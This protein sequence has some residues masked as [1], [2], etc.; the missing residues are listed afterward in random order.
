MTLIFQSYRTHDVP[1][2]I[3]LCLKSVQEWTA[4]QG[5]EYRFI[6]DR[7]FDYAPSWYR[8]KVQDNV[9]LV[10]DL[11]RLILAQEFLQEG[12]E[13]VIWMDADLL[14]FDPENFHI[15]TTKGFS[16]CREVW[17]DRD[18]AGKEVF[19]EKVNNS[20]SVFCRDEHFLDFYVDACL[21]IVREAAAVTPVLVGT[22]FLTTLHG[23]YPFPLLQQVGILSPALVDALLH[24][25]TGFIAAYLENQGTPVVAANLCGSKLEEFSG[26]TEITASILESSIEK[27]LHQK[28]LLP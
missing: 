1:D 19:F 26:K 15:P 5:F 14:V 8:L 24:K 7:L 2:W 28:R 11:S 16:F 27:L 25:K 12:Y 9:Q 20:V 3:S 6:D 18:L 17:S 10:S 23:I 13:R 22:E 21:T 4:N